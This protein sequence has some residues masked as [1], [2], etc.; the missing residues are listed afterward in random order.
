GA[1]FY[2]RADLEGKDDYYVSDSHNVQAPSFNLLHM[3]LGYST[4]S[5]SLSLWGRNLTDEDYFVK[6]FSFGNDPR[7]GYANESYFQYGEPRIVGV[8][9]SYTF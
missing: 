5:W 7:K 8:S 4:N 9:A 1:G 2:L 6:G 3:R